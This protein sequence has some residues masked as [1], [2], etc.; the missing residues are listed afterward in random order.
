MGLHK[1]ADRHFV[2]IGGSVLTSGE[3]LNLAKGQVGIFDIKDV[4]RKGAKAVNSFV[5][6]PRDKEYEIR[7]GF[8]DIEA[9]RSRSDKNF[10]TFPFS[11]NDVLGVGVSAPSSNKHMVDDV[12]IGYNGI[13][14]KTSMSFTKGEDKWLYIKLSGDPIGFM[15]YDGNEVNVQ[16]LMSADECPASNCDDCDTCSGEDCAPILQKVIANLKAHTLRGMRPL[17]DFIDIMPVTEC[18]PNENLVEYTFHCM[19]TCDTGDDT[20]LALVQ[21]QYGAVKVVRTARNGAMSTYQ[22]MQK[23]TATAPAAYVSSLPSLMKGCDTCP[24][25]YTEVAGGIIYVVTLEDEGVDSSTAVETLSGA[26]AGTGKRLESQI[27]GTGMYTVV[28][29]AEPTEAQLTTFVTANPTATVEKYGTTASMCTSAA[30]TSVAWTTC[31]TCN[32]SDRRF[33]ITLPDDECGNDMLTKL[34]AF[35]PDYTVSITNTQTNTATLTGTSGTANINVGGVNYLLTFDT[36]LTTT[37]DN[38][39]SANSAAIAAAGYT[40]TAAAGVLTFTSTTQTTAPTVTTASGD[41]AATLVETLV[42]LEAACQTSYDLVKPTNM[43][44]EECDP[45]FEDYFTTEAPLPFNNVS[46]TA[47]GAINVDG[48]GDGC[49]CG[50]RLRGKIM[51]VIPDKCLIDEMGAIESSV[52]VQVSGGYVSD[53]TVAGASED[54]PFPVTYMSKWQ[55]RTHLGFQLRQ[56]EDQSLQYF[57]GEKRPSSNMKEALTG[58]SSHLKYDVQYVDY[59]VTLRRNI[60]SQ[61]FN[62]QTEEVMNLHLLVENGYHKPVEDMVNKLAAAAGKNPAI[63]YGR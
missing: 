9:T 4:G 23:T 15:G 33:R 32:V 10:S 49:L 63:A 36:D 51:S 39:V 35:Y 2:I 7:M 29:T 61:S 26:V 41:L 22:L 34:Q 53:I 52:R 56:W 5:G 38:F 45:I 55:E 27:H 28:V 44:C 12:I 47:L 40:V 54:K 37:A 19:T 3:S 50:I 46:W 30:T 6:K 58:L 16:M 31:G 25:G 62:S 24:T 42:P 21:A 60:F 14:K 17:T 43:V 59:W 18:R 8:A 20:A 48:D 1:P 13:D 57:L 11:V